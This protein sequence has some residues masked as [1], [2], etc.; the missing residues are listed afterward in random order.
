MSTVGAKDAVGD[1]EWCRRLLVLPPPS[2]GSITNFCF[3][4]CF[5]LAMYLMIRIQRLVRSPSLLT[6][7]VQVD[8][9]IIFVGCCGFSI[10]GVVV[11]EISSASSMLVG[12]AT[13]SLAAAIDMSIVSS[14]A[15]N[16][17][18]N[19]VRHSMTY[20]ACYYG[21]YSGCCYCY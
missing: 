14:N 1:T 11:A 2:F 7:Y 21:C 13:A 20:Q 3:I 4:L 18:D 8:D 19:S 10:L 6:V 16:K 5:L 15:E 17:D 9:R 12:V